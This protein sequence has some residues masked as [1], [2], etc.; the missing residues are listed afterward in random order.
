MK[1]TETEFTP[2]LD[3]AHLFNR[4]L[5]NERMAEVYRERAARDLA[6]LVMRGVFGEYPHSE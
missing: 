5:V 1:E 2:S 4:F 6:E 3:D